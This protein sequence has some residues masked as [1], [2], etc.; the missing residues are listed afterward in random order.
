MSPR[1]GQLAADRRRA[2][3]RAIGSSAKSACAGEEALDLRLVLLA[4]QRAGGIDEPPARLHQALRRCRGSRPG[5]P[6]ARPDPRASSRH[7]ASGLRR[8]VPVPVQGASTKTRSKL[9]GMALHPFVARAGRAAWRWTMLA[10]A[11]RS[12]C[13][14][15]LQPLRRRRRRRRDG[16]DCPSPPPAPGSCRRRRRRNRRRACPAAHRPA[17]PRAAS[18]RPAPRSRPSRKASSVA[19]GMRS[20]TRRPSG[21]SGVRAASTPSRSSAARAA[22]AVGLERV[23]AQIERRASSAAPPSRAR[24]RGPAPPR[25]AA[26]ARPG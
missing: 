1:A 14:R 23:D 15:A 11:R 7:L 25:D 9:C 24:A 26:R 4:Q 20:K 3:P 8:Q 5:A 17:A 2:R 22:L 13:G 10:P 19:S 16:R 12:R 21:E 6:S 18:P